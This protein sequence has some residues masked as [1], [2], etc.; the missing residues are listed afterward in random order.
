MLILVTAAVLTLCLPQTA[1]ADTRTLYVDDDAVGADDGSSWADAF[2]Y[3]QDALAVTRKA[4]SPV[5][6]RIAQGL[7]R[8][9][10]S[11]EEIPSSRVVSRPAPVG[12]RQFAYTISR[13]RRWGSLWHVRQV[14]LGPP[15]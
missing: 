12:P 3:L 10:Q 11:R 7:Y 1:P 2:R 15:A 4:E 9:D 5:E 8:P 14:G 6:I 13:L